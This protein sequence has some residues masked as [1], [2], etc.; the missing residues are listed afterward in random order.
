[1]MISASAF[2]DAISYRERIISHFSSFLSKFLGWFRAEL[3]KMGIAVLT[4]A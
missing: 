4:D 3:D 1:M 2:V